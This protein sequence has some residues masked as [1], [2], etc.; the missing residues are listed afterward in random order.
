MGDGLL[1]EQFGSLRFGFRL[2]V[3]PPALR[4]QHVRTWIRGVPW[5]R[6]LGPQ[7]WAEEVGREDGCAVVA[8]ALAPV[9]GLIV[10]YEG[11]LKKGAGV[12]P[13]K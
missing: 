10:Q 2:L 7:G 8:R 11:L 4:L 6:A 9:L 12:S 5:P 1:L 3:E 13:G